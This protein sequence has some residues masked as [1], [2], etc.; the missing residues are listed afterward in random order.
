MPAFTA[1]LTKPLDGR[2]IYLAGARGW[3]YTTYRELARSALAVAARLARIGVQPGDVVALTVPT[4]YESVAALFA[5]WAVGATVCPVPPP[6]IQSDSEYVRHVAA[7]F[8]QATPTAVLTTAEFFDLI[9]AAASAAGA[10]VPVLVDSAAEP[11]LQPFAPREHELFAP[12]GGDGIALLQFTSGSTGT[13]RGVRVSWA[14][15]EANAAVTARWTERH[16]DEGVASWLPLYHD[17]GLIGCLLSAVSTQANLWLIPPMLFIRDPARWLECFAPGRAS[18]SA[19]PPS[20]FAYLRRRVSPDRLKQLDLSGWRCV[21]VGAEPV[22]PAVLESFAEFAA[23]AGF[24]PQAYLPAYGLA[25][26]TLA[27]T[28]VGLGGASDM[29]RPDWSSMSF[30]GDVRVVDEARFGTRATA[31]GSGWLLGY[32]LPAPEDQIVVR[33]VD[34]SGRELAEDVL[35]EI[36][37][38]GASV[39]HGYQG[40]AAESSTRFHDGTLYAGDAGFIHRGQLFIVGRMG[41]SLQLHGRNIYVE[42]LDAKVAAAAELAPDRISIISTHDQAGAGLVVFAEAKPGP[43]TDNVFQRL[44]A[45]VGPGPVVTIVTGT[46]GMIRRTSSGKARRRHMWQLFH[47][48]QLGAATITE[49]RPDQASRR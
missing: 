28:S 7:I 6:S 1:W 31:P 2:G 48:G 25:E 9:A 35:G 30:A 47:S 27:V 18:M 12:R 8:G 41:D 46:R 24:S 45:E 3:G 10:P 32:G 40:G 21:I 37:V 15:L 38:S 36:T 29:V 5:V 13:P 19:A 11:G 17:M 49:P 20:A 43:W 42:D 33:V 39:A 4:E 34:E 23:P 14:N 22:D 16:G 26:N 44:R